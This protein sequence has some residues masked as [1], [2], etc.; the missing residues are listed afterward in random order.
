MN[1]G[2]YLYIFPE[3]GCVHFYLTQIHL[4]SFFLLLSNNLEINKTAKKLPC[5][6]FFTDT[7]IF[8]FFVPYEKIL[9]DIKKRGLFFCIF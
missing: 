9:K 5:S 7:K 8:F 6:K 1:P 3:I 4:Q 2:I